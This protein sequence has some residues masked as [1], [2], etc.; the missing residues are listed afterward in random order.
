MYGGV[1]QQHHFFDGRTQI[2]SLALQVR[3]P[4]RQAPR[5]E[6]VICETLQL[7][8]LPVD[9]VSR[10]LTRLLANALPHHLHRH[11]HRG[12]RLSQF[13]SEG[14]DQFVLP[15]VQR[16]ELCLLLANLGHFLGDRDDGLTVW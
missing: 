11:P 10:P 9:H 2:Q 16:R 14:D 6:E 4:T 13:V 1:R 3:V 5:I 8:K 7:M 12:Q 15:A